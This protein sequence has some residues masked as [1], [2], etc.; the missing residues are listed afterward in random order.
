VLKH[1][2][3]AQVFVHGQAF[4]FYFLPLLFHHSCTHLDSTTLLS[5][6]LITIY[7]G[8]LCN[9]S[10]SLHCWTNN[11][12]N[13]WPNGNMIQHQTV[14]IQRQYRTY[15]ICGNIMGKLPKCILKISWLLT[16]CYRKWDTDLI[17]LW[18]NQF[19]REPLEY[20]LIVNLIYPI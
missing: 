1:P 5:P 19:F 2:I 7:R 18:N 11:W 6:L 17:K 13:N 3:S 15:S 4:H 9:L 16:Y 12:T 8:M 14:L 10:S 20:V